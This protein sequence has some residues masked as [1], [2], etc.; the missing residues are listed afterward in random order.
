M[1]KQSSKGPQPEMHSGP[2]T[3]A[4]EVTGQTASYIDDPLGY[5][6]NDA[7]W[8]RK[9]ADDALLGADKDAIKKEVDAALKRW[10]LK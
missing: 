6:T 3:V 4:S 7:A 2:E 5:D 9:A 10:K 8:V 1:S